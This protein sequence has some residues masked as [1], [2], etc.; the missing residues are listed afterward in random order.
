MNNVVLMGRLTVEPELKHTQSDIAV[1]RF[2]L[3]V[4]RAYSK[5]GTE[6]QADFI[7]IVAWRQTAEFVTKYF[8]KG[9]LVA[10]EGAIQ[11]GTY[12]DKDGNNRKSVEVVASRVHFAE[13]KKGDNNEFIEIEP[14]EDLPF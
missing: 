10:I 3:A 5:S 11:T 9:Q 2:T 4:N 12:Q 6:R 13:S 14:D 8:R 7:D 1:T